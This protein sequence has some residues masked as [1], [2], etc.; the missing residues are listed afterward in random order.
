[1]H[2]GRAV[3]FACPVWG[4]TYLDLQ[5]KIW[6]HIAAS[7]EVG[8]ILMRSLVVSKRKHLVI[9][10]PLEGGTKRAFGKPAVLLGIRFKAGTLGLCALKL[11]NLILACSART[12]AE[13]PSARA[14]SA[15]AALLR[16]AIGQGT[17]RSNGRLQNMLAALSVPAHFPGL[18]GLVMPLLTACGMP[19]QETVAWSLSPA[20][21][22]PLRDPFPWS[23]VDLEV[24]AAFERGAALLLYEQL[25]LV[26]RRRH[27]VARFDVTTLR[28][29]LGRERT[30]VRDGDLVRNVIQP[31]LA[32]IEALAKMKIELSLD[33]ERRHHRL[34]QA[35]FRV[36]A[37]PQLVA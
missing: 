32:E 3:L 11:W 2:F 6:P 28:G 26:A 12:L 19:D 16:R 29:V 23:W 22:A 25:A 36:I 15:R 35:T 8:S 21:L 18:G 7:F 27:P 33:R 24:N 31:A 30:M 1:M 14:F 17:A 9:G 10:D 34:R 20:V 13:E 5:A 4:G 37:P